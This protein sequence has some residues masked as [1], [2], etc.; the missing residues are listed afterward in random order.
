MPVSAPTFSAPASRFATNP[1]S[2]LGFVSGITSVLISSPPTGQ[3]WPSRPLP[4][5]LRYE[6]V[7]LHLGVLVLTEGA[8]DALDDTPHRLHRLAFPDADP[9]VVIGR[10]CVNRQGE[11]RGKAGF[12]RLGLC[13][14]EPLAVVDAMDDRN[15]HGVLRV[16]TA[17][18]AGLTLRPK[19]V[20]THG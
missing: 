4:R 16:E 11:R 5:E 6:A 3:W 13:G 17:V 7:D 14:L 2:A 10:G 20:P 19:V 8:D 18:A 1:T 9:N 12:E 15:E